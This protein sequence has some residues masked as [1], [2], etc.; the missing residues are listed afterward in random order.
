MMRRRGGTSSARSRPLA[1]GR[2]RHPNIVA[3]G[4]SRGG[5]EALLRGGA[6][7]RTPGRGARGGAALLSIHDPKRKILGVGIRPY[8]GPELSS[9]P[10]LR[11]RRREWPTVTHRSAPARE[12]CGATKPPLQT[13]ARRG[14]RPRR[15]T[16]DGPGSG[17]SFL[18]RTTIL[19]LLALPRALE[20]PDRRTL[21]GGGLPDRADQRGAHPQARADAVLEGDPRRHV[22]TVEQRLDPLRRLARD[23]RGAE[24]ARH[25]EEVPVFLLRVLLEEVGQTIHVIRW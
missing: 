22:P 21:R 13:A 5:A 15:P 9:P 11:G 1:F 19:L 23:A 17:S 8:A 6:E 4:F 2:A 16:T 20:A 24:V 12:N 18:Q 7:N 10:R 14:I 25:D 3:H